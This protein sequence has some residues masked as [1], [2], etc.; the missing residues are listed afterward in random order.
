[1][2]RAAVMCDG[3]IL[4]VDDLALV[5]RPIEGALPMPPSLGEES[6]PRSLK[7]ARKDA[8]RELLLKTLQ[9]L[10]GNRTRAAELLGIS[11][12]A[13]HYKLIGCASGRP[14]GKPP[15]RRA[16]QRRSR[17]PPPRPWCSPWPSLP[18]AGSSPGA[19]LAPGAARRPA[20]S[21]VPL[22]GGLR[23]PDCA[24]VHDSR[25]HVPRGCNRFL[26]VS[27]RPQYCLSR[28]P[29]LR[30]TSRPATGKGEFARCG[31]DL[32]ASSWRSGPDVESEPPDGSV[33]LAHPPTGAFQVPIG[34]KRKRT[35]MQIDEALVPG[36]IT[37]AVVVWLWGR[38]IAA[39]TIVEHPNA[40]EPA[41]P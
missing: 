25:R 24:R 30:L 20:Q 39:A 35:A 1:M 8:E 6:W 3:K 22:A 28:R 32:G 27:T 10:G 31:Q 26:P 11:L 2:E 7:V 21:A 41:T 19:V 40:F 17:P 13:L 38:T 15:C 29:T 14:R 12:R 9:S 5:L 18:A 37:S 33:F 34:L 4:D 36:A 23:S 16:R